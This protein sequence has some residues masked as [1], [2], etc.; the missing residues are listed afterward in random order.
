MKSEQHRLFSGLA[1]GEE[2]F[3]KKANLQAL[4]YKF[5]EWVEM[6]LNSF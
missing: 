6:I 3:R 2:G 1:P 5:R 4:F